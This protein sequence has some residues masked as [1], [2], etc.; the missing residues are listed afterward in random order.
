MSD[1]P[2]V[3]V[4]I[5]HFNMHAFLPA[6]VK[7]VDDQVYDNIE[8]II[9]DDG[10][11]LPL[12]FDHLNIDETTA[13]ELELTLQS[14]NHGGKSKAVN[15]GFR[16]ATGDY[17]IVLDAD[18]QLPE[19]SLSRRMHELQQTNADLCIGSF[20]CHTNGQIQSKRDIEEFVDL[21]N[22]EIIQ[23]LLI[24]VIAPFHQNAMLFSRGLLQ[25]V[26]QMDPEMLRSQ[27]KDFAIRLLQNSTETIFIEDSVYI[28]NR[29]S[30][31][32]E[33]RL[34]NRLR[35]MKYK[36][37]LIRKYFSGWRRFI[38]LSWGIVVGIGK[39]IHDLFGT[40]KK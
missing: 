10:S 21:S 7:S 5:P 37:V 28:Y 2:K 40:Y 17:V 31:S 23:K 26:G 4:I 18:D 20:E 36:L 34:A 24:R 3:S 1:P 6:A 25:R 15:E 38:F 29:Y 12:R 11:D 16:H 13:E 33:K 32:L 22:R 14:I 35:G 39:F 9:V 8:L 30:R 27:D 19:D